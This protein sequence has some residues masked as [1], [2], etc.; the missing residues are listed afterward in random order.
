MVFLGGSC[1]PTSWRQ[2]QAIPQLSQAGISY[3]NPQIDNWSEAFMV[4]ENIAKEG[5][6]VLLFVIDPL[7]RAIASMLEAT[8]LI[9]RGRTVVLCIESIEPETVV[10]D[11]V[12]TE[13]QLADL[14]RARNFLRDL[15]LR[16]PRNC[17]VFDSVDGALKHIIEKYSVSA[18]EGEGC[19]S[20]CP[21]QSETPV[22]S[23]GSSR[24]AFI[25]QQNYDAILSPNQQE[26][27]QKQ[28]NRII[29]ETD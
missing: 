4:L 21:P 1:H 11:E 18:P 12:V 10:G 22:D 16:N 26:S 6:E 7:T 14:N 5:A 28:L 15:G 24:T 27:F 20:S 29:H 2:T 3:F 13:R 8:E 25:V 17:A 9:S 23:N 19:N